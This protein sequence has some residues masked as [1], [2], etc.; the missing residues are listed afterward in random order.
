VFHLTTPGRRALQNAATAP[1][2]HAEISADPERLLLRVTVLEEAEA[3]EFL[4]RY[5]AA[6]R[7]YAAELRAS[8]SQSLVVDYAIAMCTARARWAERVITEKRFA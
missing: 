1:I 5:A 4:R 7:D 2:S 6:M 8:G 3:R